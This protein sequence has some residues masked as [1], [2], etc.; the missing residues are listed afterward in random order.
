MTGKPIA[1]KSEHVQKL[2]LSD[3]GGVED[4]DKTMQIDLSDRTMQIDLRALEDEEGILDR[5]MQ[6]DLSDRTMQIDFRALNDELESDRTMRIDADAVT[7]AESADRTMQI[8]LSDRTMQ[9]DL[10]DRTMMIDADAF[11]EEEIEARLDTGSG[12]R[13]TVS[14][15]PGLQSSLHAFREEQE[16]KTATVPKVATP[17]FRDH[18]PPPVVARSTGDPRR[19]SKSTSTVRAPTRKSASTLAGQHPASSS[20]RTLTLQLSSEALQRQGVAARIPLPLLFL[21]GVLITFGFSQILFPRLLPP[22]PGPMPLQDLQ[23]STLLLL[24]GDFGFGL[25]LWL[26]VGV[27]LH[28]LARM[29]G[30]GLSLGLVQRKWMLALLPFALLRSGVLLW[31]WLQVGTESFLRGYS[32][33]GGAPWVPMSASLLLVLALG[34][35]GLQLRKFLPA[36]NLKWVLC[37]FIFLPGTPLLSYWVQQQNAA[38]FMLVYGEIWQAAEQAWT[39]GDHER[40]LQ[41]QEELMSAPQ[42]IPPQRKSE[43]YLMRGETLHNVGRLREARE[44]YRQLFLLLPEEHPDHRLARSLT[45]LT[46]GET[47]RGAGALRR[48]VQQGE[49]SAHAYR[50]LA[51]L[52]L[53]DFGLLPADPVAA[54][55]YAEQAVT[56]EPHPIHL[57]VRERA[58]EA[59]KQSSLNHVLQELQH[60]FPRLF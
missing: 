22:H 35:L 4:L 45:H 46:L 56:L 15:P 26:G 50:W 13:V 48:M 9:I 12:A 8:D 36:G 21:L 3:Y 33:G 42:R 31:Q 34:L 40:S 44:V 11:A 41:L 52:Q 14:E 55:T 24:L 16:R 27:L 38:Q 7:R 32:Q 37:S 28:Q 58:I 5:T 29:M 23:G 51:R 47:E 39:A 18:S 17:I 6:I 10:S 43:L 1:I 60:R 59:A 19:T 53:G 2:R 20:H 54:L 57:A 25:A 30:S 49:G